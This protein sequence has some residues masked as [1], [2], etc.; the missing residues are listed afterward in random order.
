MNLIA[1]ELSAG[2]HVRS[3]PLRDNVC[4]HL[5]LGSLAL[6]TEK[7][8][9]SVANGPPSLW[10]SITTAQASGTGNHTGM[11]GAVLMKSPQVK[12][13]G[14]PK[15]RPEH[16]A[17]VKA[18]GSFVPAYAHAQCTSHMNKPA[19]SVPTRLLQSAKQGVQRAWSGTQVPVPAL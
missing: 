5:D 19:N 15:D 18:G 6:R 14:N 3:K 13:V 9:I 7:E 11:K 17:Q 10:Y 4:L 12:G 16:L 8:S 1:I 2:L